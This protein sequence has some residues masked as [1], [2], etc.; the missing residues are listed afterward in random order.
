MS[1]RG[2]VLLL[3]IGCVHWEPYA[4]PYPGDPSSRFPSSLRVTASAGAPAVVVNPFV[5]GDTLYGTS[6]GDTVAVSLQAIQAL[7][8]QRIDGGRTLVTVV[9]GLAAWMTVGLLGGGLE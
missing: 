4:V 3:L 6:R 9:G 2:A 8:R 1:S 7:E 5:R